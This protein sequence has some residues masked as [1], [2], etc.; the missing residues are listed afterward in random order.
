[1]AYKIRTDGD[2]TITKSMTSNS[3]GEGVLHRM[4]DVEDREYVFIGEQSGEWKIYTYEEDLEN[5]P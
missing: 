4:E 2:K 1:M 5:K 3:T